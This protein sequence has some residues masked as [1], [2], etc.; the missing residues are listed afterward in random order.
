MKLYV[1]FA[2]R[3][4]AY[5]G[6]CGIEALNCAT[7]YDLE[8]NPDYLFKEQRHYQTQSD[9]ASV[10]IVTLTVSGAEIEAILQPKHQTITAKVVK[11]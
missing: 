8:E 10:E 11:E 4:E 5:D 6:E 2:K 1:L 9:I 7:D 3:K